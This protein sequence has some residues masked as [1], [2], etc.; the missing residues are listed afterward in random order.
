MNIA[1]AQTTG[2]LN[3]GTGTRT[4]AI[5]IGTGA[6]STGAINIGTNSFSDI[7]I[8]HTGSSTSIKINNNLTIDSN[9]SIFTTLAQQLRLG[10][11]NTQTSATSS[12]SFGPYIKSFGPDTMTAGTYNI[13]YEG[14][15][16]LFPTGCDGCGGLLTIFI[17]SST[18]DKS[19]TFVSTI[20]KR[21]G[22]SCFNGLQQVSLNYSGWTTP[23]SLIAG[24][25]TTLNNIKINVNLSDYTATTVSW[26]LIG[27]I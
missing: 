5:N 6:G 13:L 15:N 2:V 21:V 3:I 27:F 7:Y 23:P 25:G 17:K 14:T 4:G 8:G 18:G 22:I 24:T 19:A 11:A 10:Y 20:A 26:I 9:K 1:T 16:G 12:S